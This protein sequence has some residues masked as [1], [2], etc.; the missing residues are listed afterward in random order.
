[1]F[2]SSTAALRYY[3]ELA[4]ESGGRTQIHELLA[5]A[6]NGDKAALKAIDKQSIAIGRGLRT[7]NAALSPQL[8]LFAGDITLFWSICHEAIERECTAGLLTN[9]RPRIKSI[10]DGEFAS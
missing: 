9:S 5:L 3:T 1:M 10:G 4:P 8:I 6:M 2:A 7:T